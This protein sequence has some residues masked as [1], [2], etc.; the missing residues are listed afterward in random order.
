MRKFFFAMSL[1]FATISL[2]AWPTASPSEAADPASQHETISGVVQKV[3]ESGGKV[4]LEHGPIKSLGMDLGMTMV[5]A[6]QDTAQLK[7]LKPGDKVRF[8]P[9]QIN[10]QFTVVKIE[11]TN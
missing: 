3:D 9:A 2:Q 6:V 5:F 8:E 1:A 4:T 10:G 7:G 11:K